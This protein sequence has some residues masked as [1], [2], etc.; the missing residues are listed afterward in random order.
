MWNDDHL[1]AKVTA[2]FCIQLFF[3]VNCRIDFQFYQR[4]KF[5][6]IIYF[7]FVENTE[8]LSTTSCCEKY[9]RCTP[10]NRTLS[11]GLSVSR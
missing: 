5:I 4:A 8:I 11:N 3:L 6:N 1:S 10:F 2:D 7:D 9:V